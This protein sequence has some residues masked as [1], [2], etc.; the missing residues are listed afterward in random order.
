MAIQP[1]AYRMRPKALDEIVG[2]THLVGKDKIIYR[3][4]KAK[5]LSSM[6]LYGPPGIG[7]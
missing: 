5:Q 6:I 2:Q 7:K 1:L 3:M 4:V